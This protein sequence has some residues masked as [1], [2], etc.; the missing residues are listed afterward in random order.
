MFSAS[1]RSHQN[2]YPENLGLYCLDPGAQLSLNTPQW[3]TQN[4]YYKDKQLLPEPLR[5]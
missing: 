5:L 4:L 1:S 3:K 2:A